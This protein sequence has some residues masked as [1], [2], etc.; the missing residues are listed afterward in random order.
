[1]KR[2]IFYVLV[3]LF[4]CVALFVLIEK[5]Y[6]TLELDLNSAEL[7]S[8]S[9]IAGV[10]VY[11]RIESTPFSRELTRLGYPKLSTREWRYDTIKYRF[12]RMRVSTQY[13]GT[14]SNLGTVYD[15]WEMTSAP[16]EVRLNQASTIMA[17][18]KSEMRFRI[19]LKGE[20]LDIQA[21]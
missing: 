16:D 2:K 10:R 12:K 8:E 19:E 14:T 4:G 9:V 1:M 3:A 13:Q 7:R 20:K 18:L 5:S 21:R 17:M 11:S 15:W 6:I